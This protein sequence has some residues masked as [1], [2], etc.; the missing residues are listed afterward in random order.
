MKFRNNFDMPHIS[1]TYTGSNLSLPDDFET[2]ESII[3]EDTSE[4][5]AN[6][7]T[8]LQELRHLTA[9]Q[10][11]QLMEL[12]RQADA[13]TCQSEELKKQVK[14]SEKQATELELQTMIALEQA[15][16]ADKEACIARR[17]SR[18]AIAISVVVAIKEV[19]ELLLFLPR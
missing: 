19:I 16:D 2:A 11:S 1:P 17:H 7:E 9:T 6:L 4:M 13:L 5:R 12:R 18:I 15:K 10:E 8:H 14:A 3:A